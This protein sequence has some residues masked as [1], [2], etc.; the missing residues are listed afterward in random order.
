MSLQLRLLLRSRHA[1]RQKPLR[2]RCRHAE[3]SNI[4]ARRRQPRCRCGVAAY[5]EGTPSRHAMPRR[6]AAARVDAA[7]CTRAITQAPRL[8][9]HSAH[10][11]AYAIRAML[12]RGKRTRR[13]FSSPL[14]SAPR[15]CCLPACF[16]RRVRRV[17]RVIPPAITAARRSPRQMLRRAAYAAAQARSRATDATA[18][19]RV[20]EL[21]LERQRHAADARARACAPLACRR[22][23]APPALAARCT[24]RASRP[25]PFC[26]RRAFAGRRDARLLPRC[27][28]VFA[29][30]SRDAQAAARRFPRLRRAPPPRERSQ[31]TAP[32]PQ[33]SVLSAMRRACA[34]SAE[35]FQAPHDAGHRAL[36]RARCA[37][38]TAACADAPTPPYAARPLR[39]PQ[40][41]RA[42]APP[43]RAA[44]WSIA[45]RCRRDGCRRQP[46]RKAAALDFFLPLS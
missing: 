2:Q 14:S 39:M 19:A 46:S 45:R 27:H 9:L 42:C 15:L 34:R 18:L 37:R 8:I 36:P 3:C 12:F 1:P 11:C 43:R 28:A 26:R 4:A 17:A 5:A 6:C 22:C 25:A 7:R 38:A 24:P 40:R 44:A 21:Q 33:R 20:A 16:D 13:R 23:A 32:L 35:A 30:L 31:A 41:P 29:P 10:A